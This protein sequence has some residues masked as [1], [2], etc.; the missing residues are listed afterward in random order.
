VRILIN[1][2]DDTREE[3]IKAF[4]SFGYEDNE[5]IFSSTYES[6]REF[7]EIHLEKKK[8][9]IDLIVTNDSKEESNNT[10]KSYELCL[11]KNNLPTSFS[12]SNFRISSIPII[13]YS[14][15]ETKSLQFQSNFN[16]IIQKNEYGE[17]GYLSE[18]ANG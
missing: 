2:F 15:N 4:R 5:L 9:H 10:L 3:Y 6:S 11:F 16:S 7:I 12:K 1:D 14:K 17:H 8:L 18:S 13:L